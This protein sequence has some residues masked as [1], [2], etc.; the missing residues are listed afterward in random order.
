MNSRY[1]FPNCCLGVAA[2]TFFIVGCTINSNDNDIDQQIERDWIQ[3]SDG[4]Y[5][6]SHRDKLL[7]GLTD[8]PALYAR[9]ETNRCWPEGDEFDC[10]ILSSDDDDQQVRSIRAEHHKQSKLGDF[11]TNLTGYS[12]WVEPSEMFGIIWQESISD[13]NGNELISNVY[14][15]REPV[16][17]PW[18]KTY[19]DDF[20]RENKLLELPQFYDCRGLKKIVDLG[21]YATLGTTAVSRS[22]F[23]G[24]PKKR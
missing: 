4:S 12:C 14:S 15:R 1:L 2:I 13:K 8:E 6:E 18:A 21:S 19:V 3:L 5:Y 20:M 23:F 7:D 10:M 11:S 9:R 24:G 16:S 22:D 17:G